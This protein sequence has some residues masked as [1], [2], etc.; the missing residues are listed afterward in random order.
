[1]KPEDSSL[2]LDFYRK[3]VRTYVDL[4]QYGT[5]YFWADKVVSLSNEDPKDLYWLAQCM[6]LMKQYHRAAHLILS[7]GLDKTHML[8][9]YLAAR[10]LLEAGELEEALSVLQ[11][12]ET[13]CNTNVTSSYAASGDSLVKDTPANIRSSMLYLKGCVYEALDNRGLAS[14]CYKQALQCDVHC[15]EAFE[16]LVQHQMLSSSEERELLE[17]LPMARQCPSKN[18]QAILH[19]LYECRMKKYDRPAPPNP[20]ITTKNVT[21]MS[22]TSSSIP[23][24]PPAALQALA[25]N[26]DVAT[27]K[28][29]RHYY[30]CDHRECSRITE[31][32]LKR[33]PCRPGCL[34]VHIACM[35]EMNKS[36]ELFYLAHRLVDLYPR[37]AISWFAVG[38]YYYIIG[39]NDL[40][41]SYLGKATTLEKPFGPAWLAYGHSFA[42]DR[43]HDQAITAYFKASQLMKGCHLPLLYIG[44]ECGL[45][46]NI[47][48]ALKF[49]S[50]ARMIAPE[51]PFVIHEMGVVAFQNQDY[52]AAEEHFL[53]AL[54]RVREGRSN[55]V[56]TS[57]GPPPLPP[58]RWEPLLNNLGHVCRKLRK[59]DEA[60]EYH[61][62]ALVLSPLN[63]STYT[64][65]GYVQALQ[66]RPADAVESLHKALGLRP[67]D[68]FATT[69]LGYVVDR[70]AGE[71]SLP[72][73][74]D[75][76]TLNEDSEH[77]DVI[78][79]SPSCT[80]PVTPTS[81]NQTG[82]AKPLEMVTPNDTLNQE[83]LLEVE[84]QDSSAQTH[85]GSS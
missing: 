59:Y 62:Q 78:T 69:M 41:R 1:M 58:D 22:P 50:Q 39:K 25:A 67:D 33:D 43:E 65:I 13:D 5:A 70:L 26:P 63:S 83:S 24:V 53:E 17:S 44:L 18:E 27:W 75:S 9:H 10:C 74:E 6:Y 60:L 32:V 77:G 19:F 57:S 80:I 79:D 68:T 54:N 31:S 66:C 82:D 47:P 73:H 45:T 49:F 2:N 46:S 23:A 40:A 21:A 16:A 29:E 4:H 52:T 38:C 14:Q 51:D 56:S 36:N 34:P 7:R 85:D 84:M 37:M 64:A 11:D 72:S 42:A 8:C 30:N 81:R 35:V 48:L 28:A 71:S 55:L 12:L 3:L 61:R 20:C 15:V 76:L